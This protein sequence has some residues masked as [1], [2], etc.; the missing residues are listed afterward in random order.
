LKLI[1]FHFPQKFP[2]DFW[3]WLFFISRQKFP[4][5]ESPWWSYEIWPCL[6]SKRG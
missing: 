6:G 4:V 5:A 3:N 2:Q 1:V